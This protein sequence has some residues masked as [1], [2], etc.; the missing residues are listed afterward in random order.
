VKC[1]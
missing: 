1:N